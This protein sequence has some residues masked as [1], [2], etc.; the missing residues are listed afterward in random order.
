[1]PRITSRRNKIGLSP[2][3][4]E[5]T[6]IRHRLRRMSLISKTQLTILLNLVIRTRAVPTRSKRQRMLA[7]SSKRLL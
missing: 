6:K 5:E 7:P 2:L 3:M 1:M 4:K